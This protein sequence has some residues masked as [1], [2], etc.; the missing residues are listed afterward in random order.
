M[1]LCFRHRLFVGLLALGTLP[2]AAALVVLALQL[3]SGDP[4]TGARAAIDD[5]AESGRELLAV[6]DTTQ[7][8][9]EVR[10]ALEAHTETLSSRTAMARRAEVLSRIA[11]G[12][13]GIIALIVAVAVVAVSVT[14]ARR[15]SAS[16]SAPIEELTRWVRRIEQR[17]PLPEHTEGPGA[18]EFD[19]L[20]NALREMSAAIEK[21]RQQEIEKE[22]LQAFRETARQVAHEMRG[23]LTSARLAIGQLSKLNDFPTNSGH[24]ALEVLQDETCRLEQ[25]A[26][27]FSDFGRLPEGP[28]ALIDVSELLESVVASSTPES[29][30]VEMDIEYGISIKGH[31]EPLRR[32]VQ[33]LIRNAIEASESARVVVSARR[34]QGDSGEGIEIEIS[35]D[36]P[37]IPQEMRDKIFEPYF[38]TK[39][40]GTGLG[41]AIVRQTIVAHGGDVFVADAASGGARFIITLPE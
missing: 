40:L 36:G 27:E 39:E 2:L 31:F 8:S 11:A 34:F 9:T 21:I 15:W 1:R 23:P 16:V 5:I 6:I 12:A 35:D 10:E 32:S 22:R 26:Q 25:L 41:L 17:Q 7:L 19:A 29:A 14:L 30:T 20:R 4:S 33:N 13:T 38:T 28:D 24:D 18:P 37:G 3:Q